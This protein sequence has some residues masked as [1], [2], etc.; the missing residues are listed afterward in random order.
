MNGR[1]RKPRKRA[2]RPP[3]YTT[4]HGWGSSHQKLLKAALAAWQPG[5][6]CTKCGRPMW[7]RW[8][9]TPTGRRVSAIHLGHTDDR[10]GYEGLQHDRCNTSDGASRGNRA[11]TMAVGTHKTVMTVP[12]Q[13]RAW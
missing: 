8:R 12:N 9:I 11:R 3:G 13:S 2:P 6:P 7:Q 4:A 10:T 5:D 1:Y